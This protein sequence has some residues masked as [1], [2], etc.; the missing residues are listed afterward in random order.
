MQDLN[1]SL[2]QCR[3]DLAQPAAAESSSLQSTV[4]ALQAKLL[5]SEE[6]HSQR[7]AAETELLNTQ[8]G[9]LNAELEQERSTTLDLQDQ[10]GRR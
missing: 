10:L 2:Q 3:D 7:L 1:A 5:A 8:L 6:A 4:D 9:S